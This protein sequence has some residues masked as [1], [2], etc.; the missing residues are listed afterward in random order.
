MNN[1]YFAC[2]DCKIYIDAGYR[3]AYWELEAAGV[4]ARGKPVDIQ[5]VLGAESYWNPPKDENSGWLYGQVFPSLR[6]FFQAHKSHQLVIGEL[7][8]FAPLTD[9][10]DWMQVGYC[11]MPTPRYLVE[12]L[13]LKSWDEVHAYIVE[14]KPP[15]WWWEDHWGDPSTHEKAKQKFE[16]LF[17]QVHD[18]DRRE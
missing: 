15:L 4:V 3:W 8:H 13:G 9:D 2:R 12:V 16:E 1:L 6:E 14:R 7:D 17:R 18:S 11:L 5:A 10:F